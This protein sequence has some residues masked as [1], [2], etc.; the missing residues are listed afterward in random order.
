MKRGDILLRAWSKEGHQSSANKLPTNCL[1]IQK[2]FQSKQN[3]TK[4]NKKQTKTNKQTN[5][6]LNLLKGHPAPL[7]LKRLGV[8]DP[9]VFDPQVLDLRQRLAPNSK[10]C[11]HVPHSLPPIRSRKKREMNAVC[12]SSFGR[13]QFTDLLR[14]GKFLLVWSVKG[15]LG[16]K[17]EKPFKSHYIQIFK[18]SIL[19]NESWK[20]NQDMVLWKV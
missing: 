3:K 14:Q 16:S 18:A 8:V 7:C 19:S 13:N 4:Q 6:H 9:F 15:N 10:H 2:R 12:S 20:M 1:Q 17:M 11:P 5:K